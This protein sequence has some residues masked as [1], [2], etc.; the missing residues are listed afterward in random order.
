MRLFVASIPPIFLFRQ[1]SHISHKFLPPLCFWLYF[2][3]PNA[4]LDCTI[5]AR[6]VRGK[7][8]AE[9]SETLGRSNFCPVSIVLDLGLKTSPI[10]TPGLD[11]QLNIVLF[12]L[13]IVPWKGLSLILPSA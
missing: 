9:G 8:T 3:L 13:R 6:S 2:R 12:L 11:I 5:S 7:I 4:P 1:K 10:I